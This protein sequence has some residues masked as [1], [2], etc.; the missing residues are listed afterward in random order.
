[1][2]IL[3][4]ASLY[5]ENHNETD[6][7]YDMLGKNSEIFASGDI[8]TL[9]SG[10]LAGALQGVGGVGVTSVTGVVAKTQTMSSTN[11]TVAKVYPGYIPVSDSTLFVMGTNAD[12][13][14]N[15]TNGGTYYGLTGTTGTAQIDVTS[16]TQTGASR[17]VEIV[18][19]DPF[20]LGGTGSGSGIRQAVVRFVKTPYTNVQITS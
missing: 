12:L 5:Q 10:Q 14:G 3:Y 15:S 18:K 16:G 6:L 4:G 11:T 20:N 19:V 2:S 9:I 1:M 17:V 8:V 7:R 13:T